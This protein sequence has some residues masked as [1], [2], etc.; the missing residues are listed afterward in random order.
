MD[1]SSAAGQASSLVRTRHT[2]GAHRLI[3]AASRHPTELRGR[4]RRSP[5]HTHFGTAA[6][7]GRSP[8]A[9]HYLVGRETRSLGR[10]RRWRGGCDEARRAVSRRPARS[11]AAHARL[12]ARR[13]SSRGPVRT[14]SS[15]PPS[16]PSHQ[17]PRAG[18]RVGGSPRRPA[19]TRARNRPRGHHLLYRGQRSGRT[20]Q[21]PLGQPP[22]HHRRDHIPEA[23]GPRFPLA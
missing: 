8:D 17:P 15:S 1:C 14:G 23:P 10:G 6:F 18:G 21:P 11:C 22:R 16:R 2:T 13:V 19:S 12:P 9:K 20:R 4:P 7:H 5:G 3:G